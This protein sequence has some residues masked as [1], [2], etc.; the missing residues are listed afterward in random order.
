MNQLSI[1]EFKANVTEYVRSFSDRTMH[2][3]EII[4]NANL[5]VLIECFKSEDTIQ[6]TAEKLLDLY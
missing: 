1:S 6:F 2:D 5:S 3:C 4:V